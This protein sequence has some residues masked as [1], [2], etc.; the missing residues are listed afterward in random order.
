MPAPIMLP[1][2]T[3]P[4]EAMLPQ[5]LGNLFL[6]KIKHGWDMETAAEQAKTTTQE[7]IKKETFQKDL[8]VKA[9]A[10]KEENT[11]TSNLFKIGGRIFKPKE[12]QQALGV[13]SGESP[14]E[15][16]GGVAATNTPTAP[17]VTFGDFNVRMINDTL[18]GIPKDYNPITL[19][20][21][22]VS[23]SIEDMSI[24]GKNI[25]VN[26]IK[27]D[28]G[29]I[30]KMTPIGAGKQP[31]GWKPSTKEEALELRKAGK[32]EINIGDKVVA[33][34]D[35]KL[36]EVPGTMLDLANKSVNERLGKDAKLKAQFMRDPGLRVQEVAKVMEPY[37]KTKHPDAILRKRKDGSWAW[38]TDNGDGTVNIIADS[39]RG[40]YIDRK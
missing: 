20:K 28:L 30:T 9:A 35:A 31:E 4:W 21:E 26:I 23:S 27:N 25:K 40:Y 29:E 34:A 15:L 8:E 38:I 3:D 12:I 2:H 37:I 13:S 7:Y 33:E 22:K 39:A 36:Y 24:E 18:V 6:A 17:P 19:E 5:L 10:A 16:Q 1:Q 11:W 14:G 32:T